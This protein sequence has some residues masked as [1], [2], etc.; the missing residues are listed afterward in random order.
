M[1][2][3]RNGV[4]AEPHFCLGVILVRSSM[5]AHDRKKKPADLTASGLAELGA[6]DRY[7]STARNNNYSYYDY[8]YYNYNNY[9]S[10]CYN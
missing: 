2:L 1:L 9:Y 5:P 3:F 4:K 8:S 7:C 6:G 10:Y